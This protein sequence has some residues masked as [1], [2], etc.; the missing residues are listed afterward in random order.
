M[1]HNLI[2]AF[3]I[4]SFLWSCQPKDTKWKGQ[5]PIKKVSTLTRPIQYQLKKTFAVGN[6]IFLSNEFDGARLNGVALTGEN[7]VT[8]LIT[9]ENTPINPSPWYA[10]KIWSDTEKEIQLKITYNEGVG[11]RYYPKISTDKKNWVSVD[12]TV[13][14]AD[15]ASITKGESPKLCE[16]TLSVNSDTTWV[17]AQELIVSK[18]IYKWAGELA[19]NS[20]V[21][22]DEL[23][24][25]KEGR[26]I[27]YLQ[28]GNPESKKMLMVLSRQHPPEVTGWLAMKAFTEELCASAKLTE[29]FR[30]EY[31]IYVVPCVNPDGVDHG[32]W[33]HGAGGID[34]NRDWEAFNQPETQAIRKFMQEKVA[35]QGKFYFMIDFHST[36]E[37]IYYTIAPELEGNMPGIV[38]KI[39]QAMAEDIPG[40]DPNIRPNG[41]DAQRI[42]STVSIFHEFGAEAVTYEVGDGTPRE[43]IKKKGELTAVNLME[44]MLEN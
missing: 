37:D 39:I 16:F 41:V 17:A 36:Y 38:P 29:K 11:H 25:S 9:P 22:I 23:G 33:R 28:I 1:R 21:S 3:L 26:S 5:E 44:I 15:T 34:L 10:F 7:E 27:K 18:D 2:F 6:G 4:L 43:L 35:E 8:V 13:Y 20:F 19:E 40:Y 32:H 31:C 42:N 12:S 30:D 24:K 14:L